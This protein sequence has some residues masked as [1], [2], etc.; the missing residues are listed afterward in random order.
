MKETLMI[1]VTSSLNEVSLDQP[2]TRGGGGG[3]GEA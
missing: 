1:T 3:E 2:E